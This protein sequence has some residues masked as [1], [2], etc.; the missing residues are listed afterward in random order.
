MELA[1]IPFY[2]HL[3]CLR[4]SCT[5]LYFLQP[6]NNLITTFLYLISIQLYRLMRCIYDKW[7]IGWIT[8]VLETLYKRFEEL[9]WSFFY[10]G[11]HESEMYFHVMHKIY[12]ICR[13]AVWRVLLLSF[14]ISWLT[15]SMIYTVTLKMHSFY[16]KKEPTSYYRFPLNLSAGGFF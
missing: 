13:I 10:H 4:N 11:F 8:C 1:I 5:V 6:S 16:Y 12:K 9:F 15:I 2:G 7:K 14:S 3:W